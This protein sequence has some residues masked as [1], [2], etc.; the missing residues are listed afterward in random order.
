MDE[1][2]KQLEQRYAM[3]KFDL[4]TLHDFTKLAEKKAEISFKHPDWVPGLL[5]EL[6]SW[7]DMQASDRVIEALGVIMGRSYLHFVPESVLTKL[8]IDHVV[9]TD[10]Y[11]YYRC[12]K[13]MQ[14]HTD[15]PARMSLRNLL[16]RARET[17]TAAE[18]IYNI[19]HHIEDGKTHIINF[20]P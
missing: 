11:D 4:D 12:Q 20:Q 16:C 10:L 17:Y 6:A 8:P 19:N 14:H 3:D 9:G 7:T 13:A 5:G 15:Y 2:D 1:L 18:R